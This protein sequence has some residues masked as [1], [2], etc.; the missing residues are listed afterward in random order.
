MP[1]ADTR[2]TRAVD[3]WIPWQSEE[4]QDSHPPTLAGLLRKIV[5]KQ[6]GEETRR[7]YRGTLARGKDGWRRCWH[8]SSSS[9]NNGT[10]SD[11]GDADAQRA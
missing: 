8:R 5:D 3:Y 7:I 2:W 1:F 10:I 6:P 11:A 4:Q 9:M